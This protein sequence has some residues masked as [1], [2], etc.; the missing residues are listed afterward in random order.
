MLLEYPRAI[1]EIERA[2]AGYRAAD[3]GT[4]AARV[5]RNL[6]YLHGSTAGD[7]AMASGWIARAKTLSRCR[8][9]RTGWVALT[10]GMFAAGRNARNEA[11]LLA[12]QVG[13]ATGDADLTFATLSY[14]GASLVH[15]DRVEEGMVLLDE[16][17]AAVAGGDVEDFI[18]VEEIFCQMF[19]A[20]ERARDVR[21]AEQWIRVGE[22]LPS[23][24][25]TCPPLAR[26]AAPTTAASSPPQ[27]A[28]RRLTRR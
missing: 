11:F 9:Q 7:W 17:L 28:G 12:L 10:E 18:V 14:L 2:Y 22:R 26:T 20:C 4:G 19:S 21:R 13:R 5:A 16:A 6:G 24:V 27:A 8:A 1:D 15:A 23:G 25:G 3:D